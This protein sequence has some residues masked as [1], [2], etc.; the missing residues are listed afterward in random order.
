MGETAGRERYDHNFQMKCS[1]GTCNLLEAK[2]NK[3]A[4]A[5]TISCLDPFRQS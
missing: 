1:C 4:K 3:N 5:L 2:I